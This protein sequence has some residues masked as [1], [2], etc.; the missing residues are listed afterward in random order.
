VQASL[1]GTER[2]AF[3][4][5]FSQASR[6]QLRPDAWIEHAPGWLVGHQKLF[7]ELLDAATWH[8]QRR[9]MY[10][11]EVRVP[12]LLAR[13]PE[14]GAPAELLRQVSAVLSHRYCVVLDSVSLAYYRDGRDSVAPH[15]DKLGPLR[16]DTV[17]AV[18]SVGEPRRFI[19][20]SL[21]GSTRLL[22]ALGWGD[23]LVMGGSCQA[24]FVHCVPKVKHAY[25]RMSIQFR[26]SL[27]PAVAKGIVPAGVAARA[28]NVR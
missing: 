22:L 19:L 23:L 7:E 20:R 24:T 14:T 26:Q 25:P 16:S 3:D 9:Q 2:P 5:A 17:V 1:F 6:R 13:A 27:P 11:R 10:D 21:D 4:A 12:R 15:G 18:L 28:V 8:E